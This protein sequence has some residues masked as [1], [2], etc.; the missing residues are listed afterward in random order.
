ME[1]ELGIIVKS[2]AG[3]DS[4]EY[5]VTV[6]SDEKFVYIADGKSRTLDNP[7]RK[8]R[9]HLQFTLVNVFEEY[10]EN[11]V[12]MPINNEFIKKKIKEHRNN[13]Q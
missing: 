2:I 12:H 1:D 3:H 7:K 9:K 6:G 10:N 13:N 11:G 5:Y 8:N 4:N